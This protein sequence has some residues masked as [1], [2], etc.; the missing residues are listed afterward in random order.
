MLNP[1]NFLKDIEYII[2]KPKAKQRVNVL[3]MNTNCNL[4]C[5]YCYEI[6]SREKL[7]KNNSI[8]GPD[9]QAF[10]DEIA[11]REKGLVSTVVIMGGEVFLNYRLLLEIL[12]YA[13]KMN[14]SY[15]IS[16]TTNGTLLHKFT[17]EQLQRVKKS[18]VTLEVSYD[19]SGHDRRIYPNGSSSKKQVEQNLK[20]LRSIGIDYKISYTIHKDNYKNLLYDMVYILENIQPTEIK[21]GFA[22]QELDDNGVNFVEFKKNFIPY[23]EQL[24]LSY[25]VPI[26]DLS[27]TKCGKCDKSNFEG[28]HYISPTKGEI[29]KDAKTNEKFNQF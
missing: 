23:A 11:E 24:F 7:E 6:E 26:C 18:I 29:F 20:Y 8:T 25:H 5:D 10:F 9:A 2:D 28:N 22:C 19:G 14:H 27:C 16:I 1:D 3:Y 17:K 12:Y 13:E 4:R 21:L 15:A